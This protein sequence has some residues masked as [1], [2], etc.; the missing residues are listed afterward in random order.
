MPSPRVEAMSRIVRVARDLRT[1]LDQRFE[2]LELTSQQAGVLVHVFMG[3]SSP[4]RLA[5]LLGTDTAGMTRLLDRLESKGLV[6]RRPDPS[7]R[8][9]LVVGLT[10]GGRALVPSLPPIYE[11]VAGI[12][13]DGV[14]DRDLATT[15][16]VLARMLERIDGSTG[17]AGSAQ[18]AS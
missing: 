6:V 16:R 14:S 7:D 9:A 12:V 3:V 8:R 2:V 11:Q 15:M 4:R 13:T 10:H 18:D 1:T 17:R 5:D